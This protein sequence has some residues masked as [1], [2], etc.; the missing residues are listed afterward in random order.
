MAKKKTKK[1]KKTKPSVTIN[2]TNK[3]RIEGFVKDNIKAI[4]ENFDGFKSALKKQSDCKIDETD[5]KNYLRNKLFKE[6]ETKGSTLIADFE[7]KKYVKKEIVKLANKYV[8]YKGD[9]ESFF[10][11]EL[12]K[13]FFN[14]INV[15]LDSKIT[16]YI[17]SLSTVSDKK[18]DFISTSL[19][20]IVSKTNTLIKQ[21][22]FSN[23]LLNVE[24]G[25]QTANAG[26]SAQFL[27]ISRAI[28][29]GFNCSN[30]DVRSSR[31]DAAIDYKGLIYKVQVKGISGNIVSF[32]DR[33]RGGK[34]IDTHNERNV[35][36]RVSSKDC[37]I[38]VAVDKQ[39][40]I[41]YII[42]VKEYVDGL[43][44]KKIKST[45]VSDLQDYKENWGIIHKLYE[46]DP[47]SKYTTEQILKAIAEYENKYNKK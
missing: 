33:D 5:V 3:D 38:F 14:N 2:F 36:K 37:D 45:N 42:P 21:N 24:S 8:Y 46:K 16:T 9:L 7:T 28:L 27:F 32:K 39:V 31:Y 23:N 13:D 11:K 40:G 47:R 30:V 1:T 12:F 22:G 20:K 26:D 15:D 17:Q 19:K 43:D 10:E 25:V 35:G 6:S 34:G 4:N 41:C 29:A 18:K 44:E